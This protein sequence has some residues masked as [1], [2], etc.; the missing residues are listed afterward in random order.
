MTAYEII[1]I[2]L[3]ALGLLFGIVRVWIQSKT[4]IAKIQARIAEILKKQD[5]HER[6]LRLHKQEDEKRFE[7]FHRENREDH[8]IMFKK[9]DALMGLLKP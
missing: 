8:Q 2:V 4:D 9:M 7:Q 5:E 3:T 1:V 6:E